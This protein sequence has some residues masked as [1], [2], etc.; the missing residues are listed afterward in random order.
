MTPVPARPCGGCECEPR[1]VPVVRRDDVTPAPVRPAVVGCVG[2]FVACPP[3]EWRK[4][5]AASHCRPFPEPHRA[6]SPGLVLRRE[7]GALRRRVYRVIPRVLASHSREPVMG[8]TIPSGT[9]VSTAKPLATRCHSRIGATREVEY[10]S[11]ALTA[12]CCARQE[13]PGRALFRKNAPRRRCAICCGT[14]TWD[15]REDDVKEQSGKIL[16]REKKTTIR[17]RAR[18]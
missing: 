16:E 9:V 3:C 13:I 6:V 11:A 5:R 2:C 17:E 10:A 12:H 18:R 8:A 15:V 14:A 4:V 1:A 7:S